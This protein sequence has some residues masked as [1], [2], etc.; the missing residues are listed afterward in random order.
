M[1][2]QK[3]TFTFQ[4]FCQSITLILFVEFFM[5]V[6]TSCGG[7]LQ[8]AMDYD[9]AVYASDDDNS[10]II[11]YLS[12][13]DVVEVTSEGFNDWNKINY[14]G[15]E[16]YVHAESMQWIKENGDVDYSLRWGMLKG[17]GM[18]LAVVIGIVLV[19]VLIALVFA[20]LRFLFGLLLKL[21]YSIVPC[22]VIGWIAGYFVTHDIDQTF[23]WIMWGCI[24]GAV[25]GIINI[26]M[27]PLKASND[28]VRQL[29]KDI[30]DYKKKYPLELDH[31]VRARRESDDIIV[32]TDGVRWRDNHDG[33]VSKL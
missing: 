27:N 16:G 22:G 7:G 8:R 23:K 18:G 6:L 29:G 20:G 3:F 31:G 11:G 2:Q 30:D 32:D 10:D 17:I 19:L 15:S 33:S 9:V 12:S 13:G 4:Y 5:L 21:L 26:I 1:K 24:I 28:G 25:I 14:F